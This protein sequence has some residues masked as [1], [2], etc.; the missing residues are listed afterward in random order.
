MGKETMTATGWRHD[1]KP[2]TA[3]FSGN[4]G[5]GSSIY[6]TKFLKQSAIGTPT[7]GSSPSRWKIGCVISGKPDQVK[8]K[9]LKRLTLGFPAR[10]PYKEANT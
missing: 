2:K 9:H 10:S 7:D 6:T 4:Y 5:K 1:S 3:E 8:R